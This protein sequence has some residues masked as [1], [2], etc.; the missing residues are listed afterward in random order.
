MPLWALSPCSLNVRQCH[1]IGRWDIASHSVVMLASQYNHKGDN[2][3]STCLP[4]L[5]LIEFIW[6]P[7]ESNP[8]LS[9][10]DCVGHEDVIAT[11]KA[12]KNAYNDYRFH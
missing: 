8:P 2:V 1:Q 7:E 5:D 12:S 6:L 11:Q 10:A 4:F 3:W 9:D